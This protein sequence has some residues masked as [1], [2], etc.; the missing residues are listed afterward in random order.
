M[1]RKI[2]GSGHVVRAERNVSNFSEVILSEKGDLFIEIGNHGQ[3]IVEA[4]DN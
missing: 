1:D 4:E 2:N 3:L